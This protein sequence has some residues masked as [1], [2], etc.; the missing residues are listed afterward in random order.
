M[1]ASEQDQIEED[2]KAA[3]NTAKSLVKSS[4]PAVVKEMLSQLKAISRRLVCVRKDV[5]ERLKPLKQLLPQVESLEN[6]IA[7]LS[8]WV[9]TGTVLL[10]SHRVDGNINLVES[11]LDKHKVCVLKMAEN[12]H[13]QEL[14][15]CRVCKAGKGVPTGAVVTL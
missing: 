1:A 14:S 15:G 3:N 11:R 2:F 12:Y 5:P 7:D 10:D 6:G 13:W 9:E 8:Q 4:D